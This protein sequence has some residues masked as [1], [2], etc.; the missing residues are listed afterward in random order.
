MNMK[1]K[2]PARA[3]ALNIIFPGIGYVYTGERV[4]FGWLVFISDVLGWFTVDIIDFGS[5]SRLQL[6]IIFVS[7]TL[8]YVALGIDGYRTAVEHNQKAAMK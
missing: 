1:K 6:A 3:A 7:A 5:L 4:L 8:W 2:V